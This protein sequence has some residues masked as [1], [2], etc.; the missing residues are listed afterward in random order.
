MQCQDTYYNL[1]K[2]FRGLEILD[3]Y[4]PSKSTRYRCLLFPQR[5]SIHSLSPNL[6]CS[7][8]YDLSNEPRHTFLDILIEEFSL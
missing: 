5:A 7:N 3:T 2:L 4:L 8:I 6:D 1:N